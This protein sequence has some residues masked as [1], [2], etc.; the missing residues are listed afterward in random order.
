M[1]VSRYRTIVADPPWQYDD[2]F[3]TLRGTQTRE[4]VRAGTRLMKRKPTALPYPSLTVDQI[5]RLPV[6]VHFEDD[7]ALFLWTTNRYLP[8]A[9]CVIDA[10]GFTYTQTIVWVKDQ[11][12]PF[13]ASVAPNHAEYLIVAK[14]GQHRWTGSLPSNVVTI[15]FNAK[16]HRARHSKKPEAFLDYIETIS[17]GPYLELFAR[18]QRLGWDTWGNESL[19]HV[20]MGA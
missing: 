8:S 14:R 13:V 7:A 15:A 20:E 17:A 6:A 12:A 5:A 16:D 2:G 4:Q 18:R 11:T 3:V 9:F 19:E 1:S 10:W